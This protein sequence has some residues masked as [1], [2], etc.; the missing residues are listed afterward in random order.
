M[1]PSVLIANRGEIACRIARTARRLGMRT[2]AVYSAADAGA[3][4]TKL[5]DEAYFLG[6]AEPRESYLSIERLID[7]AGKSG[8]ACIHPGYGFL[9]ENADFA[10]ACEQIG[11]VFVGPPAQAMRAMGLKDRAK[12]LMEKAGV[13]VVPGYHGERQDAKFLM[14]K[15]YEIGYPVLIKP[16]AGGGGRGMRRVD[17]HTDFEAALEGAIR[18]SQS[19]FGS[20]RVLIEKYVTSPRHIEIQV[21]A[22]KHG[23]AIHLGERDCSLQRRHQKVI[24][25]APAP[26]MTEGL[27][28]KMGATAVAAAKAVGYSGAGTVEF[29]A[30]GTSGLRADGFW[31]IEMNTRLQV[32][33]PVTEEVTGLDLVEWQFRV[34][35]GEK[36]PLAQSQIRIDGHAIEARVY[37]ED[38]E[39]GFL[40]STGKIVALEL[41]NDIRVDSGVEP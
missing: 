1:L 19:A 20:G 5:C 26:G 21:F 39:H 25:E 17:K 9:S 37:A 12:T 32:E 3:L 22:D 23:N 13:P 28:A 36:L 7:V 18:E 10:D 6:G 4:H 40:P 11:I 38:P 14:E 41:P 30:D 27:R 35:A 31:F 33:H 34:A 29:V 15:A 16:A 8:A 2:I 24:E